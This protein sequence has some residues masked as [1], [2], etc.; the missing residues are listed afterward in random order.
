MR[1]S[2][3]CDKQIRVNQGVGV[4]AVRKVTQRTTE[5]IECCHLIQHF[6]VLQKR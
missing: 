3:I 2:E 1:V 4:Y 6:T 5:M